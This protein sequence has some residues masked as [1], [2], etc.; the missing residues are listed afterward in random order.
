MDYLLR[1]ERLLLNRQD[2]FVRNHVIDELRSRCRRIAEVGDLNW[3]GSMREDIGSRQRGMAVQVNRD[4]DL[5]LIHQ[6]CNFKVVT[7]AHVMELVERAD[8]TGS[9]I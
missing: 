5:Q 9:H 8:Q 3:C 1:V 4:I 2:N 7:E 6:S